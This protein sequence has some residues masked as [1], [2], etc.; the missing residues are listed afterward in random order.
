[1]T[2]IITTPVARTNFARTSASRLLRL[3]AVAGL[4]L[5]MIGGA[6]AAPQGDIEAIKD[7]IRIVTEEK[8]EIE[9]KL[10][11]L[12]G[13]ELTADLKRQNEDMKARLSEVEGMIKQMQGML[14]GSDGSVPVVSADG[15][16][17]GVPQAAN[18]PLQ[19]EKPVHD[20]GKISD[21]AP[22][23][24]EFKFKNTSSKVVN[25]SNVQTSCGCTAAELGAAERVVQ[26]GAEGKIKIT[27]NPANRNGRESKQIIVN[28][29][30]A[31]C[32]QITLTASSEVV[33]QIIVEPQV[34]FF[35]EV[36][37]GKTPPAQTFTIM[38]R[39]PGFEVTS[40]S[41]NNPQLKLEA[42][43]TD[44][45][46]LAG[47][48]VKRY[49]YRLSLDGNLPIGLVQGLVTYATNDTRFPTPPPTMVNAVI[50]GPVNVMPRDINLPF[51][52][53]GDPFR[54]QVRLMQ[55]ES[56][57][58]RILSA[59]IEGMSP[60][61][62]PVVDIK[63][64]P[65]TGPNGTQIA[66]VM[67]EFVVAGTL[68]SQWELVGGTLVVKTDQTAME[69]IRIPIRA[70]PTAPVVMTPKPVTTAAPITPGVAVPQATQAPQA[71]V[72]AV[73]ARPAPTTTPAGAPVPAGTPGGK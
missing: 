37:L 18:C 39:K 67:Y 41:V 42:L 20:F 30:A 24:H 31:E 40:I 12:A 56:K 34:V 48:K 66:N 61:M 15:K 29:D 47:E 2:M 33:K 70:Y 3:V 16:V 64:V 26:P 45:Q 59:E 21:E 46:D 62:K 44:E 11:E 7:K 72:P 54:T 55:R 25:I 68:P 36:A 23:S 73:N 69:T 63:P 60:V 13:K 5:A 27:F 57:P 1:M 8:A 52:K 65:Y 9:K 28:T 43:G 53:M 58:M 6:H 51:T 71:P 22:V 35:G 14:G 50:V 49:K 32:P 19:F 4:S 17:V 10:A 38:G